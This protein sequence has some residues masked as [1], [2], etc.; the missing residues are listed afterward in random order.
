[1][2]ATLI[3]NAAEVELIGLRSKAG[4]IEMELRASMPSSFCLSCG[5]RSMSVHSRYR[6]TLADL[7]WEGVPVRILLHARKFFCTN[8][9]CSRSIFAERLPGTAGRYARRSSRSSEALSWVALALGG[10]AGARLARNFGPPSKWYDFAA[11]AAQTRSRSDHV[12]A[13]G[14]RH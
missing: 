4:L 2:A 12:D 1:M 5:H 3:P 7:P 11:R 13:A 9:A 6:R 8:D 10:R 14:G